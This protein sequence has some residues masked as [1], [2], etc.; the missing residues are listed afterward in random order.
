M[1]YTSVPVVTALK[2]VIPRFRK[3]LVVQYTW[4]NSVIFFYGFTGE[5]NEDVF[6]FIAAL[7]IVQF[8]AA[9]LCVAASVWFYV[10]S[11]K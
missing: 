5:H 3:G 9:L 2:M 6:T 10:Y 11:V 8:Q 1:T 7:I 4:L